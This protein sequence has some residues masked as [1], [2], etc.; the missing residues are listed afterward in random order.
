MLNDT[1]REAIVTE[2]GSWVGTPYR[3][4]SCLKGAGVD[5]GQLIY[6]IYRALDL[7][8]ELELPTDYSL[9]VAQHR[10]STEYLSIVDRFFRPISEAEVEPGDL[11]VYK[12]GLAYAHAAL[13]ISWPHHIIQAEIHHGV[14]GSHGTRNPAL[15]ERHYLHGCTP[16]F[17]TLRAEFCGGAL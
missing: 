7:V 4:W 16:D 6:G 9:Q 1:Q 12:I 11:V 5:C 3:G 2:A 14:S 17:R 15:R 13:I 10:E 8:P